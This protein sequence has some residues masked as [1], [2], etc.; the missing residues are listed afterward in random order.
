MPSNEIGNLVVTERTVQTEKPEGD[1]FHKQ[2]TVS[3]R[4]L[5]MPFCA[6]RLNFFNRAHAKHSAVVSKR[7]LGQEKFMRCAPRIHFL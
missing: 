2:E 5:Q 4:E 6:K 1:D 7:R 3:K